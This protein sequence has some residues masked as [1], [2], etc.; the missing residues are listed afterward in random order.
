MTSQEV[1]V[2]NDGLHETFVIV[3][4]RRE[5]WGR[6]AR[7]WWH[8]HPMSVIAA[9]II[10]LMA[11]SAVFAPV[12]APYD[13][14]EAD[15]RNR[16]QS[17]SWE[18]PLGTDNLGRDVL[19]RVLYGARVSMAVGLVAVLVAGGIGVPLGLISGYFSGFA[20]A[21]IMRLADAV[22]AFPALVLALTLVLV[23]GPTM[24]NIMIA[25]G[26]SLSP[27]YARICRSQVLSLKEMD[28]VTAA[29]SVGLRDSRIILKHIWPN[30]TAPILVA[31]SLN[32]GT[33]VLAEAGLSF[34]GVGVRPPTPTWGG[35]L[36]QAF[37]FIYVAAWLSFAPGLA[38]FVLTLSFN[39]LGD[40]LR[41]ML[42][43][44]LRRS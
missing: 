27:A 20:D 30:A 8:K 19:S 31:A 29:R 9:C 44:R 1:S 16:L 23:L 2:S 42:D 37:G 25:V 3:R 15:G 40:G 41:D 5:R 34:L 38:I 13:P 43:P 11:L 4:G 32:L 28:F 18:H 26:V 39:L 10:S 7:L 33:A 17:S 21:L 36:N 14:G 6:M 24:M 12:L 22:I 35:M